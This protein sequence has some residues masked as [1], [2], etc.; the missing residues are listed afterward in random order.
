MKALDRA[1][2][3]VVGSHVLSSEGR[4]DTMKATIK[5]VSELQLLEWIRYA[6]FYENLNSCHVSSE[7]SAQ[8]CLRVACSVREVSIKV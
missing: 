8:L 7:C 3:D 4:A 6:V 1:L 5:D 2:D